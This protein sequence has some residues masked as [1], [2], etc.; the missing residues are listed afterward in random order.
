MVAVAADSHDQW[1]TC[2]IDYNAVT[3]TGMW[4]SYQ[5]LQF[6]GKAIGAQGIYNAGRSPK[7]RGY[8]VG[9]SPHEDQKA[10]DAHA[11]LIRLLVE[12][13]WEATTERG[14]AWHSNRFRR[15]REV[16]AEH[17]EMTVPVVTSDATDGPHEMSTKAGFWVRFAATLIDW[18]LLAVIAILLQRM[19]RTAGGSLS[20]LLSIAYPLFFWSTSGQTPG[21]RLLG[22]RIVKAD[23]S[24]LTIGTA[25]VRLIG[26]WISVVVL[27]IGLLAVG[28]D[29]KKQGWHDKMANTYVIRV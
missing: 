2:E 24:K 29:D 22:L 1:D 7:F 6:Y 14:P 19:F 10:F 13:G 8:Q 12:H 17:P 27:L 28:I 23:G 20:V 11:A 15:R 9:G 18:V 16:L 25:I 21:H 26:E 3:G 4:T 5:T